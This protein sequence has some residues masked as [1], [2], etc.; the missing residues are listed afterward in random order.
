MLN[1]SPRNAKPTQTV[2]VGEYTDGL[3]DPNRPMLGPVAAGGTIVANTT[4][5]CWGPMITPAIRGGHEVTQPVFVEG[6]EVGDAIAI[7]IKAI[8]VSSLA[9]ASGNDQVVEGRFNGDPYCA[10]KC[11]NC[12]TE[13]PETRVEGIGPGS[14]KC[15]K[16]GAEATP[17]T[18]TNG[19]TIVFDQAK[20][21]GVTIGKSAAENI[22]RHAAR[23]AA[24]PEGSVQNPILLFAPSDLVGL[25]TRLRP[26][27]GQLG[28][29]PSAAMPD[30]HNAGDFGAFLVGAPH[31]Y[32]MSAEELAR[33]KTDGHMDVAAVRAGATIVCPVK[34]PGGGVY[35]GDMH[36][37]Q[38]DGEIAGHTCDVAGHAT[39]Q[40]DVLKGLSIDGPILFPVDEDLPFLARAMP[41]RERNSAIEI[42]KSHDVKELERNLPISFIGTGKDLNLAIDNGLQRAADLLQMSVPDVKNRATILGGIEIG[43]SPGVARVT[44][45]APTAALERV[46]LRAL[47]EEIYGKAQI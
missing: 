31:K 6:A 15:V 33:H 9:T 38:G 8:S 22:A 29:T 28:T 35:L 45:R 2:F 1:P 16:C 23:Y 18:F 24:L 25:S 37:L 12:G 46:G 26:F 36:A 7:R 30:S 21:I 4:P 14:I 10:A 40:V 5:G 44:F 3:L 11:S 47:A 20:S 32:A 17:F 19:Y 34:V 27:L 39:L 13:W 43:R 42:A 41:R